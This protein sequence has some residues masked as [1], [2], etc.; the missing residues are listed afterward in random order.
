MATVGVSVAHRLGRD[1]AMRRVA[2]AVA[3]AKARYGHIVNISEESWSDGG[4]SFAAG[5]LGQVLRGAV[6]VTDVSADL[7]VEW[8]LLLRP[9]QRTVMSLVQAKGV[10]LLAEP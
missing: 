4:F 6:D 2:Q 7:Q 5:A 8:P 9:F 10:Q 3:G 1:E